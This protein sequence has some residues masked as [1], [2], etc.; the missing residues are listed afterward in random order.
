MIGD[1]FIRQDR[2]E[3][4]K[5]AAMKKVRYG[6]IGFGGIAERKIVK[7]GFALDRERFS[8]LSDCVLT[9]ACDVD[10][11]RKENVEKWNLKWYSSADELLADPDIDAVFIATNNASHAEIG[12]KALSAGKHLIM[13]KPIATAIGDAQKLFDL[14]QEKKLCLSVDHMLEYNSFSAAAA[15]VIASGEIGEVQDACFHME[16]AFGYTPEE[17]AA[18]RCS[19]AAELG[20]PIGDL[21][22]HCFYMAEYLMQ[23][24][25]K[26]VFAVYY[27][28]LM[29]IAVEDGCFIRFRMENGF[30]GTVRVAFS[31]KRP[32]K[33]GSAAGCGYEIYGE[34]AV[35]RG[36]STLGQLSGHPDEPLM[37]RL[38]T[39]DS[40]MRREIRPENIRNMYSSLISAH[41][42]TV[43][44]GL[45]GNAENALHN[46]RCCLA[47][48]HS[49]ANG[50]TETAV[51][52]I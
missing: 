23:S 21:G 45:P 42:R 5:E 26:T 36:F 12:L 17:A 27:P 31:E 3:R 18:W 34:K 24:R 16:F 30:S 11:R 2:A 49:A 33:A 47:A 41:A 48:H 25:I 51:E 43:I 14:A 38:E 37:I 50:G 39:D 9:A 4:K 52:S 15:K 35:L 20:G 40:I 7:E 46:L 6:M 28:K 19:N 8:E 32:G 44:D 1:F 10:R 29:P 22:S 13:E